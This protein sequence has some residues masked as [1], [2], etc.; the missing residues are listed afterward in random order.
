LIEHAFRVWKPRRATV[1]R[2]PAAAVG[3]GYAALLS[4][5]LLL[6]PSETKAFIY[7]QF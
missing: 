4:I 5:A 7:F 1:D 6:A 2:I 3:F